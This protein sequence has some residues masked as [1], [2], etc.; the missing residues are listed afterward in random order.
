M[1]RTM[2][3]LV[4]TVLSIASTAVPAAVFAPSAH[5]DELQVMSY[6]I[7]RAAND[8]ENNW[9]KRRDNLIADVKA[10][11][12]DLLGFQEAEKHQMDFLT[13]KLPEYS[14]IGVGRDDG[15]D[16]GEFC[17]VFY[18]A[19]LFEVLDSG[20]FWLSETPD[21]PGKK[22]WG[23]MCNRVVSWGKFRHKANGR[24]FVFACTHFDHISENARRESSKLILKFKEEKAAGLP[25][26]VTGDFNSAD[27]DQ[28][29]LTITQELR[30]ARK[31]AKS[32]EG[33]S[34]TFRFPGKSKAEEWIIDYIFLTGDFTVES[35]RI[36]DNPPKPNPEPSDHF[37]IDA[38]LTW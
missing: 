28:A 10:T 3:T 24:E 14:Y 19:D 35:F 5:A 37:S 23:A 31:D 16:R 20:T 17:P 1:K 2:K 29:Y 32:F 8:G 9:G 26:I 21:V 6:N 34:R 18:K 27:T 4:A 33:G 36:H 38:R 22:G 25:F 15:A 7:L 30:D 13:E 11:D 12:P